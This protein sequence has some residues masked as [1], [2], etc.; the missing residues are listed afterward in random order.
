MTPVGEVYTGVGGG[1][2]VTFCV[3]Q[4]SPSQHSILQSRRI[5]GACALKAAAKYAQ[6]V[7]LSE[8]KK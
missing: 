6:A 2:A 5:Q 1:R 4:L 7:A 3:L 8:D